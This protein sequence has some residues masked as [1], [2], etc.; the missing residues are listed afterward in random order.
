MKQY[1]KIAP[2]YFN[3]IKKGLKTFELRVND[4]DY[5]EG[6][7]LVLQEW[8]PVVKGGYTGREIERQV[9]YILYGGVFGLP[10]NMCIMSLKEEI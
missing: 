6:D 10:D 1:L 3:D 2:R 7:T 5:K 9:P 4:R 8:T